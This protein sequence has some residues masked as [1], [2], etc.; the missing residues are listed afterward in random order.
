MSWRDAWRQ[1]RNSMDDLYMIAYDANDAVLADKAR[2]ALTVLEHMGEMVD[3]TYQSSRV[4]LDAHYAAGRVDER[5]RF[6]RLVDGLPDGML[7]KDDVV[8][9]IG[10]GSEFEGS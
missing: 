6:L 9:L 5:S 4:E 7:S 2:F 8:E 10:D 3:K 1:L